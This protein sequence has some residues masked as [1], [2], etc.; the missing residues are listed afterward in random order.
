LI[1]IF[2]SKYLIILFAPGFLKDPDKFNLT[3]SFLHLTFFYLFFIVIATNFISLLYALRKFFLPAIN[4]IFLN[5]SFIIGIIFFISYFEHYI[6]V[7]CVFVAG[8]LQMFFP[9]F[10]LKKEGFKFRFD[11][12]GAFKDKEIIKMFK[13]FIPRLGSSIIYHLS[14]L[15]DTIFSSLTFLVG[16]GGLAA[17]YYA[18]RLVQFPLAIIA[19]SISRVTLVDLSSYAYEDKLSDF[20]K[21]FVF[22]FQNLLFFLLPIVFLFLFL[23]EGLIEVIFKR[24]KF[25]LYSLKLTANVL[26]YYGWGLFFF[27]GIKLLVNSFYALKDTLTPT[28]TA[29]FSLILNAILSGI[30]IFPL[31]IGGIALGSSISA[32]FNFFLLY[33]LL[34]KKIGKID[35]QDTKNQLIKIVFLSILI[36]SI[37]R[38]I[39]NLFAFSKYFKIS[40][41]LVL[42]FLI[43]VGG[44]YFLKVKQ[45]NYLK[46]WVIKR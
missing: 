21:L 34:L 26:F 37:S 30:L 28:K 3:L 18:N 43:L 24:G 19:L 5:L 8:L 2:L 35:W 11:L 9:L 44:G 23:P 41:I 14:V 17:V 7:I 40:I 38:I 29:F 20:K 39:W 12:F 1:L 31:K 32:M 27:C 42:D 4:P 36:G 6:L 16:K 46:K 22:S 25:D 10:A 13:L 45:I 33:F 15:I